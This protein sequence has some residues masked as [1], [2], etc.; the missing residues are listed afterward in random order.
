[1][2]RKSSIM[3]LVALIA[4]APSWAY[5]VTNAHVTLVQ[6]TYMP[7]SIAFTVDTGTASCPAGTWLYWRNANIDNNKATYATLLTALSS[8]MP[9][10]YYV[11]N[12]DTGCTVLFLDILSG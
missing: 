8:G 1:M 10:T 11:N 5:E 9:V 2:M 4:S 3:A 12:G 6:S 7:T